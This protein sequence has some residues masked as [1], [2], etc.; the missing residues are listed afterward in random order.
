MSYP[1]YT[2]DDCEILQKQNSQNNSS[3]DIVHI[4]EYVPYTSCH[5]CIEPDAQQ[6]T[7]NL[8]KTVC[9]KPPQKDSATPK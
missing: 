9:P 6:E 8:F 5:Q 7:K 4:R 3:K 1:K 2:E